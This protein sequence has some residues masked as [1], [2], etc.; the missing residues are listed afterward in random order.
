MA[1]FKAVRVEGGLLP[2]DLLERIYEGNDVRDQRPQDFGI[3]RGRVVDEAARLWDAARLYWGEFRRRREKL[4]EHDRGTSLTRTAW[5]EP[6]LSLLGYQLRFARQATRIGGVT[7]PISHRAVPA[8][9]WPDARLDE[10]PPVHIVSFRQ[11]LDRRA[12]GERRSPH[13]LL[14]DY[15]NRSDHVWGIVTN[16]RVLRVLR[17]SVHLVRP[18]YL[19]FDLETMFE[20]GHFSDFVLLFRL[21]HRSR[22]SDT[23]ENPDCPLERYYSLAQIEGARIRE[24][25]G[26]GVEQALLTLANGFLRHPTNEALRSAVAEGRLD[27]RGLY[28]QLLRLVYRLLFLMVAEER[29]F[30][31]DHPVYRHYYSV[32]RLRELC[33]RP[34]PLDG[35][36]DLYEGL[37][38][39]FEICRREDLSR[40]LGMEP[41][42]GDLFDAEPVKD[43]EAAELQNR[44]LLEA[45]R[46]LSRFRE[47]ESGPLRRVNYAALDV[48]ELGSVYESLL[49]LEPEIRDTGT[50]LTFAF[51]EGAERKNTG[52]YYTPRE[53]VKELVDYALVPV[54]EERIEAARS[55]EEKE[56]ALLSLKVCDPACGSGHFLLAAARRIA[57]ELARVRTGEEEPSP[58]QYRKALREV[59]TRCIYGV[60]RN[61][62]AVELCKVALWIEGHEPGRPLTF[63]DHHIRCGDS[64]VGVA[65]FEDLQAGIPDDAFQRDADEEKRTAR[66]LK[67][68]NRKERERGPQLSLI[69]D[70]D[71]SDLATL[72]EELEQTPDNTTQQVEEK[73][74]RYEESRS[75]GSKW[76]GDATACHMWTMPFFARLTRPDVV[77]TT[78]TVH[79]A[80]RDARLVPERI[81]QLAW[82]MAEK[83]RFFHWP[84]EF[85]D[86]YMNGGFDVILSNPPYMG[87]L[88]ISRRLG[89][90]YRRYLTSVFAPAGGTADLC[91]YFCRRAFKLLRPGGYLGMV[92]INTISQGDT[93]EGGL[94]VI[95]R[96][97]GTITFARRFIQWP[98]RANV[99][100]NLLTVRNG[101]WPGPCR[102]DG[103]DVEFISSRLDA[104]P[105]EQPKRLQQ[106]EGKAFI[107]SYVLGTGFVLEPQEAQALIT[108]DPR[109]RD[110]LFPYLNGQDLNSDPEQR[111]S[112]WVICFFDWPLEVAQQ[113][114]DLL[115]IVAQRVK[116]ERE[117]LRDDVAIQ[118]KRK[119]FW[120]HYGSPAVQLY[121]AIAGLPRVL[122]RSQ[123][124][125]QHMVVFVPNGWI[126]DQKLVVF[127]WDDYYHFSIIQSS[128]HE[129]WA[130]KFGITLRTDMTYTP[131]T[132]FDPFPFPQDAPQEVQ[133]W[134]SSVG[135]KYHEHRRQV[136]LQR[137]IGLTRTYHLF[138]DPACQDQ[139][140]VRLRELHAEMDRAVLACYGWEDVDLGHNFYP[141]ERGHLRYTISPFARRV[142][143]RRLVELNSRIAEQEAISSAVFRASRRRNRRRRS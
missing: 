126:Y 92:A 121:Q 1:A 115:R 63:L 100:V 88:R 116:P 143:L 97:G 118:R 40:R 107:G 137:N 94:A 27:A 32:G 37:K 34:L 78:G 21:V 136:M 72:V 79:L 45:M 105:E 54:M 65:N 51:A 93:R 60:D 67:S 39:L 38:A 31:T 142:I 35:H 103:K 101:S 81:R 132:C 18:A 141:N 91:A 64:L 82:E 16:G 123:V 76:W 70:Q 110:C 19:E 111:P 86:V 84:L 106:N 139:D 133:N 17:E 74:R 130:R 58:K 135:A 7:Y 5:I 29:G 134:A 140:M 124:S 102:L 129:A 50:G 33:E 99:E 4:P 80:L 28:A 53:L 22:L 90:S 119:Q 131:T 114:P 14:Q 98:G 48:E 6:L 104:D 77:P 20:G 43:L 95:L 83:R 128:I 23:V 87:G 13:S 8:P 125:D 9:D 127:A 36:Y 59:I 46:Y 41:L 73:A 68:R 62:M 49:E 57:R 96:D 3:K 52:S 30:L 42:N 138:H 69:F 47:H 10:A 85:P 12:E 108:K 113:Y 24:R 2:L 11:E 55:R 61:P 66:V 44:D 89:D 112:R 120:W 109:N 56:Q 117:R 15:L 75:P 122:V 71:L 26:E 25:L